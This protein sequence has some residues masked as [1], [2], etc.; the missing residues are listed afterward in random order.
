[1]TCQKIGFHQNVKSLAYVRHGSRR[2][3]RA[4]PDTTVNPSNPSVTPRPFRFAGALNVTPFPRLNGVLESFIE[5][6][7]GLRRLEGIYEALGETEGSADFLGAVLAALQVGYEVRL[8]DLAQVPRQGPALVVANH[9]F[10]AIEGIIMARLMMGVRPDFKIMANYHLER[11]PPL[12]GLFISVDPFGEA[13]ATERNVRPL[14]E[15]IRYVRDGGLLVLFPA[16]EVSHLHVS[17]ARVADADWSPNLGRLIALTGAPIVPVYFHGA[18]S[19]WFQ[20]LGLL[21]PRLRTALIPHELANKAATRVPVRIGKAIAAAQVLSIGSPHGIAAYLRLRTYM[22]ADTDVGGKRAQ[23]R[24]HPARP[25]APLIGQTGTPLLRAE[26]AALPPE[27]CLVTRGALS[28]YYAETGEIH[29]LLREIGR[30]REL[31]FRSAG[32]GTGKAV[33]IDLYDGYYLHLFLWNAETEEVVGAYRLGLADRILERFGPKGLYTHS[34]FK[35]TRALIERLNPAIELGRS[36]VRAEYQKSFSSLLLLWK[37]IGEFV[38]RRPGYATLF[39]P[40]TIS[41]AYRAVSRQ[42]LVDYLRINRF[43]DRL[44]SQV[45]PRKPFRAAVRPAWQ[46]RDLAGMQDIEA[47]SG[48]VAQLESSDKG[49]PILLKH[50]LKLGGRLLAFSVDDDFNQAL[51][52]LIMVDLRGTDPRLQD[53][54]LGESAMQRFRDYHARRAGR[55]RRA[56]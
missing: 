6:V 53:L 34:L 52:G 22:L 20:L 44:A 19:L 37:G 45:R 39:G 3:R 40:L 46:L 9:P 47:L 32:E 14:R 21:H 31:T 43:E 38:A 56:S 18:N 26:I 41:S 2:R 25:Q 13:G 48:L 28:V 16:G 55:L 54:Y 11:V 50:Y 30:L 8:E 35:Y 42:L 33:D 27:R 4:R 29:W 17:E 23:P 15:A 10:G 1:M 5:T 49:V 24:T 7:L 12:R 36:F 51:D